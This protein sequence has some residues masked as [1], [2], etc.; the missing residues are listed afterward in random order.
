MQS[1]PQRQLVGVG[2]LWE[3]R[4]SARRG[5]SRPPAVSELLLAELLLLA[6]PLPLA[7]PLLPAELQA[8]PRGPFPLEPPERRLATKIR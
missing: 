3:P 8:P 5:P 7:E 6:E 4:L 2:P 1:P